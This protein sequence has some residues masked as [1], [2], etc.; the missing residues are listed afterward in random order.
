MTTLSPEQ[1]EDIRDTI[2]DNGGVEI[3]TDAKLQAFYD[4]AVSDMT[5][6]YVYA[7]RRL[8]GLQRQVADRTTVHGDNERLSQIAD[9]TKELLDYYEGQ[10]GI[11]GGGS[12]LFAGVIDLDLD[13]DI[14]D[15]SIF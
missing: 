1:I 13:T 3:L 2:G 8:W 12:M 10:A 11:Y 15:T 14:D 6:T 5:L 9:R 7:L 4:A